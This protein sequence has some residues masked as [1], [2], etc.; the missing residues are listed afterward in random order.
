M[1]TNP[2]G[3]DQFLDCMWQIKILERPNS[4][5]RHRSSVITS[6]PRHTALIFLT[7][8]YTI[9]PASQNQRSSRS[10]KTKIRVKKLTPEC[11]SS[12]GAHSALRLDSAFPS[13][14]AASASKFG[15]VPS[16]ET[17][18]TAQSQN[19]PLER[20]ACR[21]TLATLRMPPSDE[22]SAWV[23]ETALLPHE[24]E[25]LVFLGGDF[26]GGFG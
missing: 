3:H 8:G 23:V 20:T 7:S 15:F 4:P 13:P 14:A 22:P 26:G 11:P 19:R 12:F 16:Y 5:F 6:L 17:S 9:L 25:R 10:S 18:D 24:T 21:G 2:R 1:I